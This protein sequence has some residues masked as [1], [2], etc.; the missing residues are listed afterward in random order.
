[1]PPKKKPSPKST[2][3]LNLVPVRAASKAINKRPPAQAPI[4]KRFVPRVDSH[5]DEMAEALSRVHAISRSDGALADAAMRDELG[6]P[7]PEEA[8]ARALEAR[9]ASEEAD[10]KLQVVREKRIEDYLAGFDAIV[11]DERMRGIRDEASS[12]FEDLLLKQV[13][14]VTALDKAAIRINK[15]VGDDTVGADG[16]RSLCADVFHMA[17]LESL[18]AAAGLNEAT[19]AII[20][21]SRASKLFGPQQTPTNSRKDEITKKDLMQAMGAIADRQGT[22]GATGNKQAVLAR[23]RS[24][25]FG[26]PAVSN[27][28]GDL[29]DA[30]G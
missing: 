28:F 16:I 20:I 2:R 30:P 23:G 7:S 8:R 3:P 13:G 6:L 22:A 26:R 24:A 27:P 12:V 25:P 10:R 9:R 18:C 14:L 29:P 4:V 11:T 15:L 19:K 5:V 21:N 17:T 1:M